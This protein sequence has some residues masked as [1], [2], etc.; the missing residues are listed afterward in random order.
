MESYACVCVYFVLLFFCSS[1]DK[2]KYVCFLKEKAAKHVTQTPCSQWQRGLLSL[3][4]QEIIFKND[5]LKTVL[6]L[7]NPSSCF[8]D[9]LKT[10]VRIPSHTSDDQTLD[11]SQQGG[12]K[13]AHLTQRFYYFTTEDS[14]P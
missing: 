10:D 6:V 11:P 9:Y 1:L 2:K 13:E 3:G 7:Q 8:N 4:N 12:A 5:I 14:F